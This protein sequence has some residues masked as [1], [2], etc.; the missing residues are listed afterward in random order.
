MMK[1]TLKSIKILIVGIL[2]L[3][4]PSLYGQNYFNAWLTTCSHLVG[5]TG[6][7]KALKLAIDQSRGLLAD[8]PSF[9]W[10]ILI[11]VGDWTASQK[12]PGDEEGEALAQ[13]LNTTLGKDRG[14]FFTV[15]GNHDGD[16]RGWEPGE[17]TRKYVNP[18]GISKFSETSGFNINQRPDE[19]DY[20]QLIRYPGTRWDRYLIRTGNV[21]WIMLGDRNEFDTLA[22][23][24]GDTSGIFQAGRG[25][26]AGMPDG[27]YPSG[28]VTLDTFEWW[29][30]V[31]EDPNFSD[32]ILITTHHLMPMNTT[33][34]TKAGEV[35]RDSGKPYP[36]HGNS[37]SVGP[38]GEIGGQLYWI[39]EYNDQGKEI[40]Q[41]AQTRPFLNYLKDHPGA[42]AAWVGGHTHVNSPETTTNGR[43]IYV[44]KYDVTFISAG[45]LTDSHGEGNNQMTR[46]LTFEDGKD[47]AIINVYIHNSNNNYPIGWYGPA[48]RKI[49]LGKRFKCPASSTN[50]SS[51]I[52]VKPV[53]VSNAAEEMLKPRYHWNFNQDKSYDFNNDT[54]VVGEDGSPY[55]VYE[56]INKIIY[57]TD[58]PFNTGRSFDSRNTNGRINFSAPYTPEMNWKNMTISIWLKPYSLIQ[59]EVINYYLEDRTDGKFRLW[60]DGSAWVWEVGE[61]SNWKSARWETKALNDGKN[62]HHFVALVD[63]ENGRIQLYVDKNLVAEEKWDC[64]QLNS[65]KD[66]HLIIGNSN[67][68]KGMQSDQLGFIGLL[69][70]VMVFDKK[71][72]PE[73]IWLRF[74]NN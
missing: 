18:L 60:Y 17:F 16:A 3:Y 19:A 23:S 53:P 10:D 33:I 46:M 49:L 48:V 20:R 31:V 63:G 42:I 43:G 74:Y 65:G 11:D 27:G 14:R 66:Q 2:L 70:D 30:K 29:K 1:N 4:P 50:T 40:N 13:I 39:R 24:R 28:S 22:E 72:Y 9:D 7:P 12:P 62:W 35:E 71:I 69:D 34:A 36:Y 68:K 56:G 41:Y 47:E 64:K 38:D 32:N 61:E 57:T 8:A 37:G 67:A 52:T 6:N 21:I 44:R 54:H 73:E 51:P 26:A 5:P 15:S 55:G 58:T 59:Q 45:A 25:S